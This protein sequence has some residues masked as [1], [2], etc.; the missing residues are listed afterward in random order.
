MGGT[1][2]DQYTKEAGEPGAEINK[3]RQDEHLRDEDK[4]KV[5]ESRVESAH[6]SKIPR[7]GENPALADLKRARLEA[8]QRE[9]EEKGESG[10]S[11]RGK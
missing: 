8:R 11:K 1:R 9:E 2:P 5:A 10:S 6:D 3:G 7:S 4:Q